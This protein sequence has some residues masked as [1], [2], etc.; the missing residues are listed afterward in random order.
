MGFTHGNQH[1]SSLNVA[2]RRLAR[3]WRSRHVPIP[4]TLGWRVGGVWSLHIEI[5]LEVTVVLVYR[6]FEAIGINS[7]VSSTLQS[8]EPL[9]PRLAVSGFRMFE[10]AKINV[11]CRL[12]AY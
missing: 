1:I 7:S 2:L 10:A 8:L 9:T 3:I 12:K 11:Y 4:T 5:L 6:Q